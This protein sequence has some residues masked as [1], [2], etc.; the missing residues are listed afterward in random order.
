MINTAAS[1]IR[2]LIVDDNYDVIESLSALFEWSGFPVA[3]AS[4]GTDA[5]ASFASCP[6][7]VVLIDLGMPRMNG[8]DLARALRRCATVPPLLVAMTGWMRPGDRLAAE[9]AGF[10]HYVTKPVDTD[11]LE[12]LIIPPQIAQFPAVSDAR[13]VR[14]ATAAQ[15]H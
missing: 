9:A 12:R 5:L 15:V 14:V 3:V 7:A 8:F 2:I 1:G 10:H 13:P 6:A 11:L 4:T